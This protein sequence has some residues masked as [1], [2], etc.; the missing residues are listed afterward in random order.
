MNLNNI[1]IMGDKKKYKVIA[2]VENDKF[3]KYNVNNLLLFTSFLDE[4]FSN[5]RWFNVY[6]YT[7]EGNGIQLANFTTNNR[8]TSRFI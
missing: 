3:V 5:W 6:D 2:K 7:P 8:P 1:L 4:H